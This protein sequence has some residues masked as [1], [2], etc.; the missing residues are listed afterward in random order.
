MTLAGDHAKSTDLN[1]IYEQQ[2]SSSMHS[3]RIL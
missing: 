3:E 1:L 2:L